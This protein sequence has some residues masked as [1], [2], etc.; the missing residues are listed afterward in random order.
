LT[1]AAAHRLA[2]LAAAALTRLLVMLAP[3]EILEEALLGYQFLEC[4]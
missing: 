2:L 1:A 3:F 4:A